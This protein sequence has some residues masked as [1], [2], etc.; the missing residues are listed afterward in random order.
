MVELELKSRRFREQ[1]ETD[2]RRLE[3]LL[4]RLE[5]RSRATLSDDELLSVPLLYRSTLSA[6]SMARSISL[7]R[8][9]TDYLESLCT[10]AYFVVYGPRARVV[11]RLTA[12][13]VHDWPTTARD[14]WRE[15]AVAGALGLLGTA[16][17]FTL[18]RFDL[19]WFNA[20]LPAGLAQGRDPSASTAAL[21]ATLYTSDQGK[22]LAAFASFLFTHNA[23]IAIL[24]FA[25]GFAFCLPTAALAIV[26][27][28]ML[29]AIF[30]LFA[31]HGLAFPLGGWLMIHGVTELL[32]VTL[33]CAAGF[34]VGWAVT[35]PGERSRLEAIAEA[36]RQ[37][38]T[39]M[40]GV[41]V[42]LF[43]AG[44]LEGVGRQ[45]VR[46]DVARYAI[47]AGSGVAWLLYLYLPRRR[48]A[49][50]A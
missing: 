17:A 10:R 27:G 26:N 18:T 1:R 6:L 41:L 8:A 33:A 5:G 15:T 50:A 42:M 12:F 38:A 29:G 28:L 19:T 36:G 2:W 48:R 25:L 13:F 23:Q 9:L 40:V 16:T 14:L 47:A 22:P 46:D 39:L 20:F 32:A 43:V 37:G 21:R 4:D 24:A 45:L 35:F 31:A 7:D 34:R 3:G 11:E 44:A 49:D 30:A